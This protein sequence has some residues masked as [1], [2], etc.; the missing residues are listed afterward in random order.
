MSGDPTVVPTIKYTLQNANLMEVG[1]LCL[2]AW[3]E[4]QS[5]VIIGVKK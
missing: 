1:T 5:V 3:E 4:D 2:L